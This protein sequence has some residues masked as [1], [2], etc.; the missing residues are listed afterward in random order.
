MIRREPIP[1]ARKQRITVEGFHRF[2]RAENRA[3]ERML[4]PESARENF[5]QEILGIVQIHFYFFE[6]NLAFLLHVF[7]IEFRA[8][9]EVGDDV[10]GDRQMLVQDFGVEADLFLGSEGVEHAADGIHFAGDGFGGAALRALED[11]VLHEVREAV[12][13]GN[14]AA[15]AVADPQADGDGA[16]VGHS[17][18]DHHEAVGQNVLLNIARFGG[19]AN[20][21]TQAGW[22]GETEAIEL[23]NLS[24]AISCEQEK[25]ATQ[26]GALQNL[27]SRIQF[28]VFA[29]VVEGDIAVGAF[30]AKVDLASVKWLGVNVDADGA[31]VEFGEI[32]DLMDGL[33]R[34]DVGGV[35]G[36]HFVD[37]RGNN[38]TGA[39]RGVAL[40]NA[41]I[42]DLQAADRRGHPAILI[43][44]VV[45]AAGL[46]DLPANCHALED[47]VLEDEI[48]SVVALRK[49]AV[50]VERFR[51]HRMADDV[52]LDVFEGEIAPR[53]SGETFDP[54]G[55]GELFGCDVLCHRAPPILLRCKAVKFKSDRKVVDRAIHAGAGI[56]YEL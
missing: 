40:V 55:D 52:V 6:D 38:A 15:G 45:N 13:F 10:K 12:L 5:V 56:A 41:E 30:L 29:G 39:A 26:S 36:V 46:A 42:L 34:V 22:K 11:H 9:D 32:Q 20:I 16:H 1:K 8:Q 25:A 18:G 48:A 33:E 43:A 47:F 49:I 37:V 28:A 4:R 24:P 54:I 44:M 17:L 14:F 27:F 50:F 19:H 51:A 23:L 2:R 21:V 7:G 31:L 3:P 53:D 35:R